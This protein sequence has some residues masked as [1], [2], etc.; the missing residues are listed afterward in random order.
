MVVFI[1]EW[2]LKE[3]TTVWTINS[4]NHWIGQG[5]APQTHRAGYRA[6]CEQ[7]FL[8][9]KTRYVKQIIFLE[10]EVNLLN[11]KMVVYEQEIENWK[12]IAASN[13][14]KLIRRW[15]E[16]EAKEEGD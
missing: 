6:T 8:I 15:E 10:D 9:K 2:A 3:M 16:E 5:E 13:T 14:G 7:T 11:Q 1:K 12:Q 4:V